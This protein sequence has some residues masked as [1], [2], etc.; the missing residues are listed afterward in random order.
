[1]GFHHSAWNQFV[2]DAEELT[3][4]AVNPERFLRTG[5]DME[6]LALALVETADW[7]KAA[8]LADA[9]E[10]AGYRQ[11]T[12]LAALRSGVP[13]QVLWVLELLLGEPQGRLIRRH[14]GSPPRPL[15]ARHDLEVQFPK[16][17]PQLIR[18]FKQTLVRAWRKGRF[19]A[20][21]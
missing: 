18:E 8:A 19:V 20:L 6:K 13:V 1:L 12:V 21:A 14:L 15:Q 7:D 2:K 11:V 16:V 5:P 17:D 3:R 10:R 9:L 4:D